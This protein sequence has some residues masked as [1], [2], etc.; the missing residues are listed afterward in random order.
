MS[1]IYS[2]VRSFSQYKEIFRNLEDQKIEEN[3]GKGKYIMKA[4][5]NKYSQMFSDENCTK[6]LLYLEHL[7]VPKSTYNISDACKYLYYWL[8]VE[9]LKKSMSTDD[10]LIFYNNLI[11]AYTEYEYDDIC[12]T[13]IKE[14]NNI[15]LEKLIDLYK[16]F[17]EISEEKCQYAQECV[18]LYKDS[19]GILNK[20][21]DQEFLKELEMIK[22]KYESEMETLNCPGFAKTCLW[23]RNRMRK[24]KKISL[25]LG[26]EMDSVQQTCRSVNGKPDKRP[27]KISYNPGSNS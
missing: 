8:Y 5:L 7:K 25:I 19:L 20:D 24:K 13:Y 6:G 3:S 14:I 15:K 2:V 11:H 17:N 16:Y 26:Q 10:T 22:N 1:E 12:D 4:Y 21:S 23:L 27:Y 18:K 9:A